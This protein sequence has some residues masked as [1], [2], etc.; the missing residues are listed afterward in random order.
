MPF[1]PSPHNLVV[2]QFNKKPFIKNFKKKLTLRK[3]FYRNP[4]SDSMQSKEKKKTKTTFTGR[5]LEQVQAQIRA[6][7]TP[8]D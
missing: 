5:K 2:T 1:S 8:A 6:G 7:D 4:G 3:P